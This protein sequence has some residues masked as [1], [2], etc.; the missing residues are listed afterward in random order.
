MSLVLPSY[1]CGRWEVDSWQ[2]HP[3]SIEYSVTE[4]DLL[5]DS[6]GANSVTFTSHPPTETYIL[7]SLLLS[8]CAAQQ[9]PLKTS[10]EGL[11]EVVAFLTELTQFDSRLSWAVVSDSLLPLPT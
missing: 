3:Q 6:W 2:I 11:D 10:S 4:M 9:H 8:Y 7:C 1:W 5:G